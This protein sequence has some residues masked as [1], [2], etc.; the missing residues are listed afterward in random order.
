MSI[1]FVVHKLLFISLNYVK[2]ETYITI[3]TCNWIP[4]LAASR[5]AIG[6]AYT[7]SAESGDFW[8]GDG[9][10]AEGVGAGA[11]AAG[12]DGATSATAVAAAGGGDGAPVS[13]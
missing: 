11:A 13:T 1:I 6:L 8:G 3:L 4:L 10:G 12:A 5:F 2:S 9:G 7:L